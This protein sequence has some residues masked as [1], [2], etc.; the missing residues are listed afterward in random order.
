MLRAQREVDDACKTG[1]KL[2]KDVLEDFMHLFAGMAA[3]YQPTA[4]GQPPNPH[5]NEAA[6]KD[7]A[8]RAIDCADKLAPYQS[9][10]LKTIQ[11]QEGWGAMKPVPTEAERKAL[12]PIG[13]P[14]QVYRN[15]IGHVVVEVP[16]KKSVDP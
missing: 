13:N 10:K 15:M 12:R 7:A 2:A 11:V 5:A 6:F 1:K 16:A 14:G 9:P 4:P 3:V 8:E